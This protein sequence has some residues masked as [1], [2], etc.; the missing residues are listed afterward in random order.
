MALALKNPDIDPMLIDYLDG[1]M[2][3]PARAE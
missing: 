3:M 2:H 1:L